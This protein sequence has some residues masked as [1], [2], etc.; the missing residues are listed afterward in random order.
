MKQLRLVP[1][2]Y[3]RHA[4]ERIDMPKTIGNVA[5]M[6]RVSNRLRDKR[7][8][9]A[10]GQIRERAPLEIVL[11]LRKSLSIAGYHI[12]QRGPRWVDQRLAI[13]L[14]R[15]QAPRTTSIFH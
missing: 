3:E 9:R 12:A 6:R 11:R 2:K 14:R 8:P 4:G 13:I 5:V 15:T 7:P 10:S 1:G